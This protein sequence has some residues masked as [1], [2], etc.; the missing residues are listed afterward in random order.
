MLHVLFHTQT[1]P[2]RTQYRQTVTHS[3]DRLRLNSYGHLALIHI[4]ASIISSNTT[5]TACSCVNL[6]AQAS[7]HK[8]N[9]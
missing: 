2:Y 8:R 4:S 5:K 3:M 9:C 6:L 7:M 1:Q